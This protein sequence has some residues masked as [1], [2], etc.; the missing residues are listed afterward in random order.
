MPPRND[1]ARVAPKPQAIRALVE[2]LHAESNARHLDNTRR[3]GVVEDELVA[4]NAKLDR[5]AIELKA[6]HDCLDIASTNIGNI[7]VQL[8]QQDAV[9][10]KQDKVLADIKGNVLLLVVKDAGSKVWSLAQI[11]QKCAVWSAP[12]V[13]AALIAGA[14]VLWWLGKGPFPTP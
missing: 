3:F 7:E 1:R 14:M 11:A 10:E 2:N 6:T 5:H 9:L 8:K 12:V 4:I 13:T